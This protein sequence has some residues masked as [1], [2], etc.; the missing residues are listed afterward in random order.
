MKITRLKQK[1]KTYPDKLGHLAKPPDTLSVLGELDELLKVPLVGIVG[2]RKATRYGQVVTQNLAEELARTGVCIISGLALGVDSI[3]HKAALQAKGKTIAVLPSGLKE[4]YPASHRGLAR[5]ILAGGGALIS[6][7]E[8]GFRPR[9]ESFIQRNRIIAAL[10]DVLLVTEAAEKSG[11]LHTA[12]FALELG[13]TVLAVP[14]NITSLYSSGTNNLLK[15]GA[16]MASD[17]ND[18]FEAMGIKPGEQERLELYGDNSHETKLL[19]LLKNGISDADELLAKS[20]LDVQLFQQ[21]LTM[22]EIKGAVSPL[23]NN[24]W[25]IK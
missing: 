6:E 8:D 14:G 17:V 21:T 4:I 1:T 18:I 3:A 25:R 19:E 5:S 20:S 11:S 12:N 23:G 15:A 16:V 9:R 24:H 10:S 13:K 7:Y 2:S 22:L